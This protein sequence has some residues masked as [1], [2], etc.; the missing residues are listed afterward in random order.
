MK[1]DIQSKS[2]A[3]IEEESKEPESEGQEE[4]KKNESK[5]LSGLLATGGRIINPYSSY[6]NS[7]ATANTKVDSGASLDT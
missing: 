7:N 2:K 4:E 6:Q 3:R 1:S 5:G